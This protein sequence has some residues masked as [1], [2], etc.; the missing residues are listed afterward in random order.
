V[1]RYL[2][3]QVLVVVTFIDIKEELFTLIEDS[4]AL[5][6]EIFPLIL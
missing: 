3:K 5:G 1:L 6:V 2:D 4:A